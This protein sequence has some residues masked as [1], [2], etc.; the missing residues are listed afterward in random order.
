MHPIR[1]LRPPLYS[2][3]AAFMLALPGTSLLAQLADTGTPGDRA[4]YSLGA[5]ATLGSGFGTSVTHGFNSVTV[6]DTADSFELQ[7]GGL[8]GLTAGH[9]LVLYGTRYLNGAGGAR[10]GLD[11][12]IVINGTDILVYGSSTTYT[13]DGTNNNHFARGGAIVEV[14]QGD[15]LEIQ[16]Q[17]TDNNGQTIIQQDADLQ[18]VK[19][20]DNLSFA[21]LGVLFDFQNFMSL[22]SAGPAAVPYDI[23][24]ELDP[25]F[26]HNE[27]E[28]Q[29]TLNDPAHYLV[30]ANTGVRI[31]GGNRHRQAITQRLTLDG[32]PV[33]DSSTVVYV[34]YAGSGDSLGGLMEYGSTSLGMI[35]KTDAPNSILEV[36]LLRDNDV[37]GTNTAV[38]LEAARSGI[39]ILKLPAYGDYLSLSGPSQNMNFNQGNPETALSL[40]SGLPVSNPSFGYDPA[41]STSQV[42]VNLD[43]DYLFLASH[44]VDNFNTPGA[45]LRT[46]FRQGFQT[47]LGGS[48]VAEKVPYGNGGAYHRDDDAGGDRARDSGSWSGAILPLLA[49]DAVETTSARYGGNPATFDATT[50]GLQALSIGSISSPPLD[51]QVSLSG[52]FNILADSQ[53]NVINGERDLLTSDANTA[54][55]ELV[56]TVTGPVTGGTLQLGGVPIGDGDSFT[57]EEV[58]SGLLTFDAGGVLQ[59]GGFE[60]TVSDGGVRPDTGI[61]VINV[62]I[63]TAITADSASADEDAVLSTLDG[64]VFS[65]LANDIGSGLTVVEHDFVSI[66]GAAVTVAQD[67]TFTY[68]PGS[69]AALQS[70]AVGETLDDSFTYTVADFQGQT[71]VGTVTVLVTGINDN[72][73]VT[74]ES[75]T[76]ING[77]G[78]TFNLLTNESD[79]DSSNVLSIT[80]A[81]QEIFGGGGEVN[82]DVFD[83]DLVPLVF[84]SQFGATVTV[85]SDGTFDYDPGTSEILLSLSPGVILSETFTYEIFDG[86]STVEGLVTVISGGASLP[87][88][89]YASISAGTTVNLNVLANDSVGGAAGTP[90]G[91][92]AL[93]LNAAGAANTNINWANTG[94]GGGALTMEGAGTA[95]V[96]ITPQSAPVGITAAYDLSGSGSGDQILAPDDA[97]NL[98]GGNISGNSFT[99][100]VVFRPDD[101]VGPEPIWGAGGNGTGSSLVLIDDQLIFTIGNNALVAQ[102]VATIPPNAVAGG[103]YVQVIGTFDI[104]SD[105]A[106]LY[107]NGILASQGDAINITTGASGN[108]LD[109]SGADDEG[110]GRSAGT[111][112]G[113]INIAPFLGSNGTVDLPDFNDVND[114]YDGELAIVRVYPSVLSPAEINAN[115]EA[116]FGTGIPATATDLIGLAG[117]AVPLVGSPVAL[118]SGAT[119]TL[120]ADGSVTYD[121]NGAFGSVGLGLSARD[122][123]TYT[124]DTA[125]NAVVTVN[126]DV[127]GTNPDPQISI[128]GGPES[129]GE[130]EVATLFLDSSAA[131]SGPVSVEL[132]FAGSSSL[133]DDF[134]AATTVEIPAGAT[135]ADLEVTTLVDDLFEGI[136]N[137]IISIESVSGSAVVGASS[138]AEVILND[139][140]FEPLFAITGNQ[141][142]GAEG[143][144]FEFTISPD[145]VSQAERAVTVSFSGTAIL[146]EDFFGEAAL[147]IP[148]GAQSASITFVPFDDGLPEGSETV[149]VNLEAVDIG[150]ISKNSSASSDVTDGDGTLLFFADFE[151]VDPFGD[152]G[153]PNLTKVGSDAPFAA[154]LGTS[155][156]SWED[157]PQAN[158]SGDFPGIYLEIDDSKGDG[159]DE[160]LVLDRPLPD[161]GDITARLSAPADISG[162]NAA[163]I[164]MDLGNRRTQNVSEAKSWRIIG[165]DD[166]G[167]KSFELYVS[168]NNSG[169]NNEQLHHVSA[170]GGLTPLGRPA[171][172]DNT[173]SIEEESEQSRL[174]LSLNS[175][176]YQVA[177]DRWPIEG[178][179]DS[180]SELLPYAGNA[181][182]IS[183]IRFS[184]SASLNDVES[185]GIIVDDLTVGGIPGNGAPSITLDGAV[186]A[187][188]GTSSLPATFIAT[189]TSI[190]GLQVADDDA[191]Q[192]QLTATL[193]SGGNAPVTFS[194][195]GPAAI[196]GNGTSSLTLVGTLDQINASLSSGITATTDG[197]VGGD[198]AISFTIDDGGNT[199]PG[200]PKSGS[201]N[202]IF[203]V[204]E[205]PTVTINQAPGQDDP[206]GNSTIAFEVIFSEAVTGFEAEDVDLTGSTDTGNLV[207]SVSGAGDAYIVSVSGM[208]SGGLIVVSVAEGAANAAAG[209]AET[210]ASLIVDASV[211]YIPQLAP[212]ATN[213]VQNIQYEL[214]PVAIGDI[215]ITDP[216]DSVVTTAQVAQYDFPAVH[217]DTLFLTPD[218]DTDAGFAIDLAF[219][220][221]GFDDFGT[222]RV[223]E[224]GGTSNGMGIYLI[225]GIPHFISKMESNVNDIPSSLNDTD[226]SDGNVCVPLTE[227]A[228]ALDEPV[229]LAVVSSLDSLTF[230]VNGFGQ[231]TV[232][233]TGRGTRGNWSGDDSIRVGQNIDGG[234]G[235]LGADDQG[236]FDDVGSF[237]ME[238]VVSRARLWHAV[239]AGPFAIF[240]ASSPEEVTATLSLT[241]GEGDLTE[242]TG[243]TYDPLTG[244]WTLTGAV[245]EVNAALA[246]VEFLP[247]GASP[248]SIEVTIDDGDEDGGGPLT[249]TITLSTEV[250][251]TGDSDGDGIPDDYEL[252]NG[253]NPS[254]PT[255]AGS[256]NDNDG[257]D[258]LS[259][260]LMGTSANNRGERPLFEVVHVSPTQVEVTYG[261]ILAGR[262]YEVLSSS[263]GLPEAL[264]GDSFTAAEDAN[265]NTLI[266]ATGEAAS[267]IYRL[268]VTVPAQ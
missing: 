193:Q 82:D 1:R 206:T 58:N 250:V 14:A 186:L 62:G 59:A 102:T 45:N 137:I 219:Q 145:I 261:P 76:S 2:L 51:P 240:A 141:T 46:I 220:P 109:W 252:A 238:G 125:T 19:L 155:V 127:D 36:E 201:H 175:E 157:I 235:G 172:F 152:P 151:N 169:P 263:S 226:W 9:H 107:V 198:A 122:S 138:A 100:E 70:L 90:T 147:V 180:V 119:V 92:A 84:T 230:S 115:F 118:P 223:A 249:G 60:Y 200:G 217:E 208:S 27:G 96:L 236:I 25:A 182:Q 214:G 185:S 93:D 124:L 18:L 72:P 23:Q 98:Y 189:D 55:E 159:L 10:S 241:P 178:V 13:R 61:F 4:V 34:R 164:S 89:D 35:I 133:N 20:D 47:T 183:A 210:E 197:V 218:P 202:L 54:A 225:D 256:D 39:S 7:D 114:R 68:A 99:V 154:N 228:L 212:T 49:G 26:G 205:G 65:V 264:A 222:V 57:Q 67:G 12:A 207:A 128:S 251:I 40:A 8:V 126:I 113:D 42:T 144:S 134:S 168:G 104:V 120:E 85:S 163:F 246:A 48:L 24:D 266:D 260:Y 204:N 30:F 80:R 167:E 160:A 83:S 243:A 229:Q 190:V 148:G 211:L 129:V 6:D 135:T 136:E 171:D 259:E 43:G 50:V 165:L 176:G 86:T 237:P 209:G 79:V 101:Q 71:F 37:A 188:G 32:T 121:T 106:S 234:R 254:D 78:S 187:D 199:G 158:V 81:T 22:S 38:A 117:V 216:N 244:I 174:I 149:T 111:T 143:T 192:G 181:T 88:A 177:I 63:V 153:T 52:P 69:A 227:V 213:L 224:I 184:L 110:I 21:R 203:Y 267:E 255:D 11:N 146:G 87:T 196:T 166:A 161:E 28:S 191:G 3:S 103:D 232:E 162:D 41:G 195:V 221:S 131:V 108:I 53:G 140:D 91:G 105:V 17:R 116:V 95:S 75:V 253:L 170:N 268:Q 31:S 77:V 156:G 74:N 16:S 215:T 245:R 247:N 231:T 194:A 56:Y 257:W 258:A 73:I 33:E 262:T 242:P 15:T 173:G 66:Q 132:R 248:V 233:L 265:T 5:G 97:N 139:N 130:G 112:G 142:T 29:I 239:D 150:S 94:S 123:F 179:I 64:G 44:F